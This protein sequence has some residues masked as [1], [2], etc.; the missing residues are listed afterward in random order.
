MSIAQAGKRGTSSLISL[1]AGEG[2]LWSFASHVEEG[3][4]ALPSACRREHPS[5]VLTS[6]AE[7]KRF[8]GVNAASGTLDA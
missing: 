5:V 3:R 6:H 4:E 2:A 8:A 1:H 7:G